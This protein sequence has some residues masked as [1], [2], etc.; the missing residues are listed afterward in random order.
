MIVTR[1]LDDSPEECS[2]NRIDVEPI[3]SVKYM[4][5]EGFSLL[6]YEE[7]S[8]CNVFSAKCGLTHNVTEF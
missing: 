6:T 4:F 8:V 2:D 7:K 1:G 3:R 5:C